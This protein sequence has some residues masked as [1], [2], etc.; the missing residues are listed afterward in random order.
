MRDIEMSPRVFA[1][2]VRKQG[3]SEVMQGWN[4]KD[5][6]ENERARLRKENGL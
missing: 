2:G 5:T 3:R 4:E 1:S 6:V